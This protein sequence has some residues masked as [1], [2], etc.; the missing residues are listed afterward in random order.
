MKEVSLVIASAL[1][2]LSIPA[3]ATEQSDVAFMQAVDQELTTIRQMQ[4]LEA[5]DASCALAKRLANER[6]VARENMST[7]F[8]DILAIFGGDSEGRPIQTPDIA[9]SN[10]VEMTRTLEAKTLMWGRALE[11]CV[12][13]SEQVAN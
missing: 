3:G 1:A 12:I 9:G 2:F 7:A 8:L 13:Y 11:A 6:Q 5:S 10:M 4:A